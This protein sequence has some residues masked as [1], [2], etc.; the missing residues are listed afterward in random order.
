MVV[1]CYHLFVVIV[2]HYKNSGGRCTVMHF[3]IYLTLLLPFICASFQGDEGLLERY[4]LEIEELNTLIQNLESRLESTE[5]ENVEY[6]ER[7]MSAEKIIEQLTKDHPCMYFV[8]YCQQ[9]E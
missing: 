8:Y 5:N 4:Q 9:C 6:A 3:G 7:L 1:K 2:C